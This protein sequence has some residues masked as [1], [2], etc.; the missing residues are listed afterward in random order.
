MVAYVPGVYTLQIISTIGSVSS[1]VTLD[2]TL[3]NPCSE[4]NISLNPSPFFDE[5]DILGTPEST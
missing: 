3:V 5:T 4:V 2:L 1:S